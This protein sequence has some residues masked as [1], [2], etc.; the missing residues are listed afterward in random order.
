MGGVMH[1]TLFIS[2]LPT[3]Y[4]PGLLDDLMREMRGFEELRPVRER[5]VCFVQFDS[6]PSAAQVLDQL[7]NNK[8]LQ[9]LYGSER[10]SITYANK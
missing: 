4:D 3:N 8:M 9:N 10:A 5:G 6:I 1:H 7:Q 2:E